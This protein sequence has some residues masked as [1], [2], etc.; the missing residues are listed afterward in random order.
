MT[1]FK[2]GD[3]VRCVDAEISPFEDGQILTVERVYGNSRPIHLGLTTREGGRT[4]GWASDRFRLVEEVPQPG[5]AVL[6]VDVPPAHVR[7]LDHRLGDERSFDREE[8]IERARARVGERGC[9]Q[10]VRLYSPALHGGKPTWI[11]QDI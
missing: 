1:D 4:D 3:R 11:I 6:V 2:P 10:Q 8:A 9:R 5:A 7:P